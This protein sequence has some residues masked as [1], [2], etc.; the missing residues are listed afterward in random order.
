MIYMKLSFAKYD[1]T[2]NTTILVD[3]PVPRNLHGAVAARL[4]APEGVF[5]EQ[6]GYVEPAENPA[7]LARLQMMGGEFCGNASMSLAAH[8]ALRKG[9][10]KERVIPL[11]V[12]GTKDVVSV[13]IRREGSGYRCLVDMPLP[14]FVGMRA[15]RYGN[16]SLELPFARLPGIAFAIP[17]AP[18]PEDDARRLVRQWCAETDSD[19]FGILLPGPDG[20]G[21]SIRPL[22]YVRSTDSS[23]WEHG[24][25]SGT[26]ALG[27][28]LAIRAGEAIEAD[29]A[30]PG[31][32]IRAYAEC[33]GKAIT[34]LAI[35][36]IVKPVCN[37]VA[38]VDLP[39]E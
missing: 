27:A 19:A 31:G 38:Y 25:G 29:I 13:R 18:M 6:V 35:E 2:G 17:A 28:W 3:S 30:Q 22:V 36:G 32:V 9:Y 4:M 14:E 34:R 8:I 1:P 37:G 26:S 21:R 15:F 10:G 16:E 11:E 33:A 12:S 23:V 5:A 39:Y 24:C 20:F 7:A